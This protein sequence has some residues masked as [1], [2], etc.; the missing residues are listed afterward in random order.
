MSN[1]FPLR[2]D[3]GS[4]VFVPSLHRLLFIAFIEFCFV[5]AQPKERTFLS[6]HSFQNIIM[7]RIAVAKKT[8]SKIL[9]CSGFI[10]FLFNGTSKLK[11]YALLLINFVCFYYFISCNFHFMICQTALSIFG[12][13]TVFLRN[14]FI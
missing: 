5:A 6:V 9:N 11:I 13:P 7:I 8:H 2:I 12:Q 14:N 10:G 4:V 1:R 3:V